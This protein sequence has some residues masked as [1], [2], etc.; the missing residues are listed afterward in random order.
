M[1]S[2]RHCQTDNQSEV[3]ASP[4]MPPGVVIKGRIIGRHQQELR[5]TQH[6]S[7]PSAIGERVDRA[8]G[9]AALVALNSVYLILA[10]SRVASWDSGAERLSPMWR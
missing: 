5:A 7:D 9:S 10:Q 3:M 1:R 8:H 6:R 4:H 2:W